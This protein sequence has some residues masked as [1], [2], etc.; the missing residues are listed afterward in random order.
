WRRSI[1]RCAVP[2]TYSTSA[3]ATRSPA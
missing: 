3:A 2:S 1:P